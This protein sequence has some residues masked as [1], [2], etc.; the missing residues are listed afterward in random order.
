MSRLALSVNSPIGYS[1]HQRPTDMRCLIPHLEQVKSQLGQLP[2]TIIADA[3]YGGEEGYALSPR[4]G[5][6]V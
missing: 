4:R 5:G 3:G 2:G 1:L 6:E